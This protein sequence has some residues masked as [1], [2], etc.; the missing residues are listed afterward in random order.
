M[1]T[2]IGPLSNIAN[3][4]LSPPNSNCK[5][6]SFFYSVFK[7]VDCDFRGSTGTLYG[8]S[9][10][11]LSPTKAEKKVSKRL[12]G[13]ARHPLIRRSHTKRVVAGRV[14]SRS[15]APRARGSATLRPS[16]SSR[17]GRAR[18]RRRSCSLRPC[19]PPRPARRAT[20]PCSDR[21]PPLNRSSAGC[22]K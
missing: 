5:I 18:S 11:H 7:K 8:I 6:F 4:I 21:R 12:H 2:F 1:L 10:R 16:R 19:S 9:L 13:K 20:R 15:R 22:L 3:H 17:R 14:S